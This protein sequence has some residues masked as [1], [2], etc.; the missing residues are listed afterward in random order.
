MEIGRDTSLVSVQIYSRLSLSRSRGDPLKH[1]G[2]YQVSRIEENTY[3][4]TNFHKRTCNLT[5]LVSNIC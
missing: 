2:T 3:R 4:T 5:S 1:F